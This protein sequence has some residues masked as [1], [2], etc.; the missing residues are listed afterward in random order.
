MHEGIFPRGPAC[1]RSSTLPPH[2]P[3]ENLFLEAKSSLQPWQ[4]C[5]GRMTGDDPADD[6][7]Q[8]TTWARQIHTKSTALLRRGQ[9]YR[10]IG[11]ML[12]PI[13]F[14][15]SGPYPASTILVVA[16]KLYDSHYQNMILELNALDERGIDVVR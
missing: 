7:T 14:T 12:L 1:V 10:S 15:I 2:L 6:Q 4:P 16:R 3:R 5:S 13:I 9:D 11:K 8:Q